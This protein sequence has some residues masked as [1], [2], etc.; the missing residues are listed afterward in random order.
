[1]PTLLIDDG[2]VY[3]ALIVY[4]CQT[5]LITHFDNRSV[6]V[7]FFKV[8]SMGQSSKRKYPYFV[9]TRIFVIQRFSVELCALCTDEHSV[10]L[11]ES[12][13][14]EKAPM[15]KTITIRSAISIELRLVTERGTDIGSIR[16]SWHS[17][18]W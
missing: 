9:D 5:K 17:V 7:K 16:A 14:V 2:P 11:R 1:L 10:G 18:G 3:H 13:E 6:V 4:L 15:P 12:T 8:Q